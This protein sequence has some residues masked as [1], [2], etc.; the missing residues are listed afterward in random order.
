MQ[1]RYGLL[2]AATA[3]ALPAA[4]QERIEPVVVT[5]NRTPTTADETLASV[6]VITREE[7]EE[8]QPLDVPDLLGGLAGI[9]ISRNGGRGNTASV[10]I[11]GTSNDQTLV[12][13]DGVRVAS[14]TTGGAALGNLAPEQIERIE[15]VRGPRASLY[16]A[17]AIGG[18]IQIF[19]RRNEG[20]NAS[21]TAGGNNTR[22]VNAGYGRRSDKGF[23]SLNAARHLTDG[24]DVKEDTEPDDDGFR[25]TSLSFRGARELSDR[26]RVDAAVQYREGEPRFDGNPDGSSDKQHSTRL[27]L[28]LTPTEIW[29]L[30]LDLTRAFDDSD[31]RAFGGGR[32]TTDRY[33]VTLQNDFYLGSDQVLT[34]GGDF[35]HTEVESTAAFT[36]DERDNTGVFGQYQW[37]PGA[38]DLELAVRHDDNEAFGNET[39]GSA[40]LGY[41]FTDDVRGFVSFG[42]AFKAPGF[43]DLFFPGFGNPGLDPEQSRSWEATLTG[44]GPIDWRFSAF[45]TEIDDLIGFDPV[46]FTAENVDNAV[47]EGVETRLAT[48]LAGFRTRLNATLQN[49]DNERTGNTLRR[50]AEVLANLAVSREIGAF[51]FGA[52]ARYRGERYDDAANTDE[53]GGFATVDLRASWQLAPQWRLRGVV[54]NALDRDYATARTSGFTAGDEFNAEGRVALI[55]LSWNQGTKE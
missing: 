20:A 9:D 50:R 42:T 35:R 4:A 55:T 27:G 14:A 52:D 10:N 44:S 17:D 33:G 31:G 45:R 21:V 26:A 41:Q 37:R 13:V 54:R 16:G 29:D 18:V 7:I 25:Q 22:A 38:W 32:F 47:I 51:R 49:P 48:T 6:D 15:V 36:E 53:L 3:L 34:I 43:N 11:R 39:T 1:Y 5:A 23:W 12:L 19:T 30:S 46:T 2:A 40:A 8:R 24:F 28:E